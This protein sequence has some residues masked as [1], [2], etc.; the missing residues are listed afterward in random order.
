MFLFHD[1]REQA[2]IIY[3]T[4]PVHELKQNIKCIDPNFLV[5]KTN[6]VQALGCVLKKRKKEKHA[7]SRSNLKQKPDTSQSGLK[8]ITALSRTLTC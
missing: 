1:F 2:Y 7:G 4:S 6:Y 8:K 3:A 5:F